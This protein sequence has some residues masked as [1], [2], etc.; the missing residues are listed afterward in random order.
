MKNILFK[1]AKKA[2]TEILETAFDRKKITKEV[3]N[4]I[5]VI[6]AEKG[7]NVPLK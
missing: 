7:I 2:I 1:L 6:L 5:V 3:Y 4:D